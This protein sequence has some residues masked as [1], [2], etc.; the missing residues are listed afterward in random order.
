MAQVLSLASSTATTS[1]YGFD[2]SGTWYP[3][4]LPNEG[5]WQFVGSLNGTYVAFT[6]STGRIALS[7]DFVTWTTYLQTSTT[8]YAMGIGNGIIM[9]CN[10]DRIQTSTDGINWTDAVF[11]PGN[12]GS[13]VGPFTLIYAQS[14]WFAFGTDN[15]FYSSDNGATWTSAGVSA[16]VVS[17]TSNLP[18]VRF[19][20]VFY[21]GVNTTTGKIWGWLG[22][23]F[24][25]NDYTPAGFTAGSAIT[26]LSNGVVI[27]TNGTTAKVSTNSTLSS[28]NTVTLPFSVSASTGFGSLRPDTRLGSMIVTAP[29]GGK[30]LQ[31]TNGT[32]WTSADMPD[33]VFS[34]AN[35]VTVP[36]NK[37]YAPTTVVSTSTATM[38]VIKLIIVAINAAVSTSNSVVSKIV[39]P[40]YSYLSTA[41]VSKSVIGKIWTKPWSIVY[42]AAKWVGVKLNSAS[43]STSTDGATWTA[44]TLPSSQKWDAIAHNGTVFAAIA[45]NSN[46]AA[47][48]DD[49]VTWTARSL[50][51][52]RLWTDMVA[53]GGKFVAVA[54]GSDRC[55]VSADG[56]TWTEYTMPFQNWTAIA[57]NGTV[58]CA[59][60]GTD[61]CAVSADGITW[62]EY[63]MP[64]AL[65][66]TA[67]SWALGQFTAVASGP[68]NKAARSTDGITWVG[69]DMP[70]TANWIGVGPGVGTPNA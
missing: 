7:A 35:S 31:T 49:G 29:S 42:A 53:G 6:R 70:A 66:Y 51:T 11:F 52:S 9:K 30:L 10:D 23:G 68:T 8:P 48:S 46:V 3:T 34:Q 21:Y 4:T 18:Q 47:S 58:F 45:S 22:P 59:V 57:H 17:N 56:I 39:M 55:A 64:Y 20:G 27:A 65:N 37:L 25:W 26:H 50:P 54:A 67:I 61:R 60:S 62:S 69:F 2:S 15:I 38:S 33:G 12:L 13:N 16:S 1:Y 32:T 36:Q 28:W 43:A 44:R 24:S 14:K 41:D 5:A 40:V 19:N 63:V